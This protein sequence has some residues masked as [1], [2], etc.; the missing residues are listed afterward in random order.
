[1]AKRIITEADV[2]EAAAA[3]KSLCVTPGECIVTDQARDRALELGVELS[4]GASADGG[5]A[6]VSAPAG[7][8]GLPK[9][10]DGQSVEQLVRQACEAL[11]GKLPPGADHGKVERLVREAIEARI[12]SATGPAASTALP[13]GVV[14]IESGKAL[15][16]GAGSVPAQDRAVLTEVL[17]SPG[18]SRL[19]AGY[20]VWEGA[21]FDRV[22]EAPEVAIVIEGE[23]HLTVGGQALIGKPG[24][25][26]YLPQGAKVMY[27]APAR[28]KLACVNGV[29]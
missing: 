7:V 27:S 1:M 23:L 3:R 10:S 4:G 25:M 26:V 17:G 18:G 5:T 14:F 8:L 16:Q 19:A 13:E 6:A 24:D 12:S 28:V 20:L 9:Q 29:S 11:G 22:V 21:S 2:L 15:G